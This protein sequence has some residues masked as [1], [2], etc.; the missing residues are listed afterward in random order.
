MRLGPDDPIDRSDPSNTRY[1]KREPLAYKTGFLADLPGDLVAPRCFGV[2]EPSENEFWLWL[3][4]VAAEEGS[5][6]SMERY[7]L[8]P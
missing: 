2:G 7:G 3:E 6:W 1:W 4:D 5:R 8:E